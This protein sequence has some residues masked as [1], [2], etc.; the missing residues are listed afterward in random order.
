MTD[1]AVFLRGVNVGGVTVRSADLR[2]ALSGLDAVAGVHTYLA[3]GNVTLASP[4]SAEALKARIEQALETEFGYDAWVVVLPL[5]RLAELAA[6]AP[7]PP[8][9]PAVH[10]Y[11]TFGSEPGL[12]DELFREASAAGAKQVRLGPEALAWP[13]PKGKTLEHPLSK[14]SGKAQYK[15]GTTTRNLRTLHKML[16]GPG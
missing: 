4:V 2:R 9:D 7:Y 11:V 12:L 1:Y 5:E 8:D 10:A 3:S 6:A 13:C 16:A 15:A 14:L